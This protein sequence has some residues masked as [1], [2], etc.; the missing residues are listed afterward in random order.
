MKI[1]IAS[2]SDETLQSICRR[3]RESGFGNPDTRLLI[4][5]DRDPLGAGARLPDVL[6][7]HAGEHIVEQLSLLAERAGDR[8][9]ALVV[10]GEHLPTDAMKF[11]MRAG[12]RDFVADLASEELPEA[13]L[14]L[15][16]ELD[17]GA[18]RAQVVAVV[19]AKGGAGA[20]FIAANLAHLACTA[21]DDTILVDFDFQYGSLAHYLDVKPRRSLVDALAHVEELDA[22]AVSAYVSSHESGVDLLAPTATSGCLAVDG[23][24]GVA[25]LLELLGERYRRIVVDVPRHLDR[26]GIEVL[27]RADTVLLVLQQSLLAVND[28]VRLKGLLIDEVGVPAGNLISVVNRHNKRSMLDLRDL[29][30]ALGG[31]EPALIPNQYQVASECAELGVF[32]AE[33]A[34]N[35]PIS[36]ALAGLQARIM[37]VPL[38]RERSLLS[39][40]GL[41][42]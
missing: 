14:R 28:A 3:V 37:G 1:L 8:R 20:S 22:T 7:L 5:G 36:K 29:T 42:G 27:R 2:R 13:L 26:A 35:T 34:P 23:G 19:N 21:G 31:S 39:R 16:A 40:I 4:N 18:E 33:R 32:L 15:D 6:I 11:A 12:A 24:G 9:P 25:A 17:A 38:Q 41:R 30:E 10:V